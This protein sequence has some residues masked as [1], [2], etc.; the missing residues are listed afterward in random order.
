MAQANE[1]TIKELR[2][3]RGQLRAQI[4]R[5]A[6]FVE[7][8]PDARD[9][10][11]KEIPFRR[12]RIQQAFAELENIQTDIDIL[13]GEEPDEHSAERILTDDKYYAAL[14]K[15][16]GLREAVEPPLLTARSSL[17]SCPIPSQPRAHA[18]SGASRRLHPRT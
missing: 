13:E 17:L 2:I 5:F 3:R 11:A 18:G 1:K 8:I 16:E 7:R 6:D 4:T 9:P 12:D 15:A 14:A 10:K